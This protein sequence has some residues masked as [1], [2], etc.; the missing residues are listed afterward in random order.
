M[1]KIIYCYNCW[2]INYNLIFCWLELLIFVYELC[3]CLNNFSVLKLFFGKQFGILFHFS[4]LAPFFL[5]NMLSRILRNRKSG[6]DEE[7]ENVTPCSNSVSL[8]DSVIGP[9]VSTNSSSS[10]KKRNL[11]QRTPK[12]GNSKG[13]IS[14]THFCSNLIMSRLTWKPQ[15]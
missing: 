6:S 3:V 10:P 8:D 7:I 12:M 2:K 15:F 4:R 13:K 14:M 1:W 9:S 5:T 11:S